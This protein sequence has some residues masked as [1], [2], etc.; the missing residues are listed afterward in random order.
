MWDFLEF[1]YKLSGHSVGLKVEKTP[2]GRCK[3]ISNKLAVYIISSY[4]LS[5]SSK[6]NKFI[7][8]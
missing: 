5:L 4:N 8:I 6:T 3:M 7:S 2:G 1:I